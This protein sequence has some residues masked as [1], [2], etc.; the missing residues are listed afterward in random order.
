[1]I[2]TIA[3]YKGGAGKT[4]TAVHLAAYL[5][6]LKPTLLLDGDPTR[7]ALNWSQRADGLG[8]QVAPISAA[9]KLAPQYGEGKGHIVIDT[10]QRPTTADLREAVD[11]SD[12][13][14]LPATPLPL[15]T[16]GLV[17]T[18]QALQSIGAGNRYRVLLTKVQP[19]PQKDAAE[20]RKSLLA[21]SVPMF[22]SEIPLLKAFSN[23]AGAGELVAS[24]K[25]RNALRAAEAYMAAG[26]E[27]NA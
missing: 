5:N 17:Q 11:S 26:R 14:I 18:I 22:T 15:D 6:T 25:D 3:S 8:F 16:D 21:M 1:M 13:L 27:L 24:S 20:L 10:G 9:A 23:A 12:L 4:T 2:I 19:W 7:N